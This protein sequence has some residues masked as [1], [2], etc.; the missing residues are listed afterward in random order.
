[1]SIEITA[2]HISISKDLQDFAREKADTLTVE[3]PKIEFVHVVLDE[4]RHQFSAEFV[5]QYKAMG[6]VESRETCD[7]LRAAID[8]A[9][10]K[11]ET[12]LRR[13]R[14]KEVAVHQRPQE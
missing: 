14:A 11:V 7:D 4:Q 13:H 2:R 6:K 10:D 9:C 1:M 12:Q 8:L 3:F 5:V